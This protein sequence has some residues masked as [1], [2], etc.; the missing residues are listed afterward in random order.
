MTSHAAM[1]HT[2]Q[3]KGPLSLSNPLLDTTMICIEG[4]AAIVRGEIENKGSYPSPSALSA[5]LLPIFTL[6]LLIYVP[7][8]LLVIA[9][10]NIPLS[11]CLTVLLSY[12]REQYW[13]L[14]P[15]GLL[16]VHGLG[17][18]PHSRA[19]PDDRH[20]LGAQPHQVVPHRYC[21]SHNFI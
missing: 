5:V 6:P 15:R 4:T 21:V 3:K 9:D 18:L 8:M 2:V 17:P 19:G 12:H 10:L 1:M 16:P 7:Y 11:R 13:P 14:H 20:G